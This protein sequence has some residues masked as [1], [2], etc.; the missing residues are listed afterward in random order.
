MS[1]LSIWPSAFLAAFC[2]ALVWPDKVWSFLDGDPQSV[3]LR[4]TTVDGLRGFLAL[5][6]VLHHCIISYEFHQTGIW[7]LPPSSYYSVLGQAGVA[8]FFM[9]TAFLFWGRVLDE[10]Y[11][12]NLA[13]FY[14]GRIFRMAPLYWFA[15]ILMFVLLAIKTDFQIHVEIS[16]LGWQVFKWLLPGMV[17][18]LPLIN[19][20]EHTNSLIAGVVWT[21]YYEWLFYLYLP[22]FALFSINRLFLG[23]LPL[24]LVF[25]F[26]LSTGVEKYLS[27]MF[28]IGMLAA[29]MVRRFPKT[30]GDGCLKSALA[31]VLL[32]A[33]LLGQ[34]TAYSWIS[35][36][37]LGTFFC[38]ICSGSSLFG[39]LNMRSAT[40]LGTISYG[41]YILQGIVITIVFFPGVLG[42]FSK[43][44]V[45]QFWL[46]IIIIVTLLICLAAASYL[47][48]EKPGIRIGKLFANRYLIRR[49]RVN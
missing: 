4:W 36:A 45:L 46:T 32:F 43:N 38:L 2:I 25:I 47:F 31:L 17:K 19:A 49:S 10:K 40:R 8:V 24:S 3:G 37:L 35:V 14:C 20:Y 48:I 22:I 7:K 15:I 9:I 6:V 1:F 12:I 42:D 23:F 39:L 16:E 29:A 34:S 33:T 18:N 26:F 30:K 5:A 28:T 27:A 11:K 21:L 44:G 41:I 13:T